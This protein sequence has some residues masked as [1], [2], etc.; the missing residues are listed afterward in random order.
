M[1]EKAAQAI[2]K[3]A[4]NQ[5]NRHVMAEICRYI[6][7]GQHSSDLSVDT[8]WLPHRIFLSKADGSHSSKK[9]KIEAITENQLE[10][11]LSDTQTNAEKYFFPHAVAE[12]GLSR[13]KSIINNLKWAVEVKQHKNK[14][15][16][17]AQ[18]FGRPTKV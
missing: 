7:S 10:F 15:D 18:M 16:Q 8:T 1:W 9:L 6:G 5:Q 2:D 17:V 12:D 11:C 3:G 14:F 4:K 13:F